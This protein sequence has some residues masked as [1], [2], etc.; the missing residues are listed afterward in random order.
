MKKNRNRQTAPATSKRVLK[1]LLDD[2]PEYPMYA[3]I[4]ELDAF[5]DGAADGPWDVRSEGGSWH[6]VAEDGQRV[7]GFFSGPLAAGTAA[8]VAMVNPRSI[9]RAIKDIVRLKKAY[10]DRGFQLARLFD[11]RDDLVER[12][13]R[14]GQPV[15][16]P[17]TDGRQREI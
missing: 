5:F 12:L 11:E 15:G 17:L 10:E 1:D 8:Y 4:E 2:D 3:Y 9:R 16:G 13:A 6:L 7:L 14:S